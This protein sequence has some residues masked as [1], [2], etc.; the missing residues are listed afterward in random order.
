MRALLT[1]RVFQHLIFWLFYVLLYTSN[2]TMDGKY[3]KELLITLI[4]LPFHLSFVYFQLYVLV[5]KFLLERKFLSYVLLTALVTKIFITACRLT[6]SFVIYEIR[7]GVPAPPLDLSQLF[8]LDPRELK[9][10]FSLFMI[11][12]VALSIKLLKKWFYEHDRNLQVEKEKLTMEVEM[13]KAQVHPHFLFNTLNNLYSLTLTHSGK[14]PMVVTHL[15]DLLRYMLYECDAKEVPLGKEIEVLKKYVELEKLRYGERMDVSFSCSGNT[16][17]LVIA[18]LLLLPFV[19]NSFKHGMSEELDQCWINIH[20]HAKDRQLTFNL[21]NSC[22]HDNPSEIAG[23]IGLENIKKRLALIYPGKYKLDIKKE[24][25]MYI[26]RLE[27]SLGVSAIP[28]V[29]PVEPVIQ[30]KPVPSI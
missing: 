6:F 7:N 2:Y 26:V 23:G 15:S 4:Y 3:G 20:L 5:P 8:L 10:V 22:N 24:D 9:T 18:P 14:A 29:K 11:T 30:L 13:L 16:Q 19:E 21:S 12:G 28:S 25:E 27:L 17:S 1:N